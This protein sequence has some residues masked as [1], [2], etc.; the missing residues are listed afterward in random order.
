MIVVVFFFLSSRRRHTRC[1]LVTGVQT[2]ALPI[3]RVQAGAR[4]DWNP[5]AEDLVTFQGDIQR[6]SRGQGALP[7][8]VFR[9]GNIVARWN[10]SW[11][12]A[13]A[14]QL[15]FYYD[16]AGRETL[17][18]NGRFQLDTFDMDFQHSFQLAANHHVVWGGGA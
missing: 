11:S 7:D 6:G 15:Q 2:C 1:A 13:S 4:F 8:E 14:L 9:G 17:Q 10:R 16:H 3:Y 12:S 18:D 5:S